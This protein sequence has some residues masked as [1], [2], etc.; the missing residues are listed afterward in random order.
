MATTSLLRSGECRWLDGAC[1]VGGGLERHWAAA[2]WGMLHMHPLASFH[3]PL[4]TLHSC[5][6][7]L[8][9]ATL[10]RGDRREARSGCSVPRDYYLCGGCAR[11]DQCRR[12]SF[13]AASRPHLSLPTPL[14]CPALLPLMPPC[15]I[16][17][18]RMITSST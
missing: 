2:W 10:L 9:I 15:L 13:S 7:I 1:C 6:M 16:S 3:H 4:R 11:S 8:P 14:P 17:A 12:P 5:R 18:G